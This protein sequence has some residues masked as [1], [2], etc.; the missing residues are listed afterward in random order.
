MILEQKKALYE[1]LG[2]TG[3]NN[4]S[5]KI[6]KVINYLEIVYEKNKVINLIGTK[7]KEDIFI[8]HILDSLSIFNIKILKEGELQEK[9]IIDIGTGGG[10]PGIPISIFLP[11]SK[12]FLVDKSKKK[13][14]FLRETIEKLDLKNIIVITDR[15]EELSRKASFREEFDI[16]IARAVTKFNI[17]LEIAIPFC[18][19]NGK[20]IFYKSKK[21]FE[22]IKEHSEA[23][24][25]LGGE[26]EEL[27][28]VEVPDLEGFRTF[29]ILKK[30]KRTPLKYPRNFALIK[31]KPL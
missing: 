4:D 28:D 31:K 1:Y 6:D 12:I 17:L 27:Y 14:D 29:L 16:V 7:K 2:K 15:A 18:T 3:I 13:T 5:E 30:E 19:I 8:K 11:E 21:V 10:L 25:K 23:M 20:I 24:S 22:E 26:F 9:K